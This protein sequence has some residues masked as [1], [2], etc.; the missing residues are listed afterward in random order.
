MWNSVS[1]LQTIGSISLILALIGGVLAAGAGAVA[2]LASNR[3]ADIQKMENDRLI[4]EANAKAA[5]ANA[6]A[7]QARL[8]LT[9]LRAKIAWRRV[10]SAQAEALK[11][12][13]T[14]ETFEV[15]TS[16]VGADPESTI[17]RNELDL[18]LQNAGL[19]T[20]YFSG[21]EVAVGTKVVGPESP[22]KLKLMASLMEAGLPFVGEGPGA[23]APNDLVIIVGTKPEP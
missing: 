3:A 6:R 11:I 10:T 2:S 4:A 1:L 7:E 8:E 17:F 20:K 12:A 18:A 9:V 14:G 19:K 22:Q 5:T 23:F 13:L 21:W 15:W 16:F